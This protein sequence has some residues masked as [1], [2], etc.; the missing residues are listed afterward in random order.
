MSC[1]IVG[2]AML[3]MVESI[4]SRMSAI[5]TTAR[6]ARSR[7]GSGPAPAGAGGA[8]GAAV[9]VVSFMAVSLPWG[10]GDS[11]DDRLEPPGQPVAAG[12]Q[13]VGEPGDLRVASR[14]RAAD[15]GLDGT[16]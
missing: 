9:L 7:A 5:S 15:G 16:L 11:G 13:G 6:M 4:R 3:V 2:A 10:G 14:V 12:Q 1:T 8:G